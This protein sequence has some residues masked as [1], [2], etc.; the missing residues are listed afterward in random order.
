MS[1]KF[2]SNIG[3]YS[4]WKA[5]KK[6]KLPIQRNPPIRKEVWHWARSQHEKAKSF[7]EHLEKV[8]KPNEMPGE[9]DREE[10]I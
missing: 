5:T 1:A 7:A 2:N 8:Y 10:E 3:N 6:L 9:D 4:L